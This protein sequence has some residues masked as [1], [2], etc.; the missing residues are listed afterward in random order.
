M[1]IWSLY[2]IQG[3]I[4][5]VIISLSIGPIA[6]ITMKRA[7]QYGLR[8]GIAGGVAVA[9]VDTA[10]ALLILFGFHYSHAFFIHTPRSLYILIALCIFFYGLTLFRKK[11]TAQ[12]PD[13]PLEKHFTETV[14][15]SLANPSTYISFSVIA[16]LLS[17]F[18]G[19]SFFD[20][21]EVLVGFA[22]GAVGW[23]ILVAL[24]S[25]HNRDRIGI[26]FLQKS[27]GILIMGLAIL[28]IV[29]PH[30]STKNQM[31]LIDKTFRL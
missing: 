27:V 1:H 12:I 20:R 18:I 31:L 4:V 16:L 7:A 19:A 24:F 8:A 29:K 26:G 2:L 11:P 25:H 6:L 15:L 28:M 10:V 5:G 17:R 13:H 21:I 22:L 3:A 9:I 30:V 23:W 14:L